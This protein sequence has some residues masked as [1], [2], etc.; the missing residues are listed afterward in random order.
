MS[1]MSPEERLMAEV[2][3]HMVA[4]TEEEAWKVIQ[5]PSGPMSEVGRYH[6][7]AKRKLKRVELDALQ[8]L[9]DEV[10]YRTAAMIFALLDGRLESDDGPLPRAVLQPADTLSEGQPSLHDLFLSIWEDDAA[11]PAPD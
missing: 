5:P 7:L 10:S 9:L 1:K 2:A 4:I 11:D 6:R 3:A 8:Q